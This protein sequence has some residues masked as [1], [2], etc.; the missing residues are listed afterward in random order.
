[1]SISKSHSILN[2][3]KIDIYADGASLKSIRKLNNFKFI[4]GFTSNPTLMAKE[5]IQNFKKFSI[6]AAKIIGNKSL[7]VEVILT[8]LLVSVNL[9][10]L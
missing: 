3:L 9:S 7:S 2:K 1:M 10:L 4:K 6:E 8:I 5:K